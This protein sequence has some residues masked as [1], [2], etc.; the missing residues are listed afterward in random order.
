MYDMG[1]TNFIFIG[2][3]GIEK[4]LSWYPQLY[5]RVGFVHQFKNM[6]NQEL[7][8]IFEKHLRKLHCGFKEDD[9]SDQEVIS[10]VLR[11]TNGNFRLVDRIIKQSIRIMKVNCM[12]T[13]TKEIIEAAR[14]CLLIGQK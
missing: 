11:I 8:F 14:S 4:T 7:K 10:A 5:S 1:E 9:Y 12:T 6:S 2:M 3:P 13:I